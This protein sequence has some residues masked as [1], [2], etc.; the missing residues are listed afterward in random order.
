MNRIDIEQWTSRTIR[1][2]KNAG[3]KKTAQE[4]ANWYNCSVVKGFIKRA[5]GNI[6]T[7]YFNQMYGNYYSILLDNSAEYFVQEVA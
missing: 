5:D 4:C 1:D 3:L 2:P 6:R 7:H